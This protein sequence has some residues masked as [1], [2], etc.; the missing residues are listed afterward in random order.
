MSFDQQHRPMNASP[1]FGIISTVV[2]GGLSLIDASKLDAPQR[3]AVHA[4]TAALTGFYVAATIAGSKK[5]LVPLKTTA[6]IAA[7][8]IALHF[9]D[10]GDTI[11]L[12]FQEKL[13]EAGAKH[14]R[15]WMAVAAAAATFAGYLSDRTA[16]RKSRFE[17]VLGH[18]DE[19]E[20]VL[21][22]GVRTIAEGILGAR[23]I[24][25][26][27]ELLAQLAS[28]REVY[29]DEEFTSTAHFRIPDELPRAV[30]HNQ[31]FPV[32]AQFTGPGGTLLQLLLHIYDGKLDMLTVDAADPD[33]SDYVDGVLQNWPEPTEV[34]HVIEDPDGRT[35]PIDE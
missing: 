7:T 11:E 19:H 18:P 20:R 23:D 35:V 24:P 26:A 34:T 10:A 3:R 30:P 1:V 9:A 27:P 5:G 14:P 25:G 31:V 28:A 13:R 21:D 4:V 15:R 32:R 6:G 16:A 12:R 29:W 17:A 33:D 2:A 8:G 22:S